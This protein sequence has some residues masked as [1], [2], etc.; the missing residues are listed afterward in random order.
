[1]NFVFVCSELLMFVDK[2]SK[3]NVV[4][5]KIEEGETWQ[6][7][8]MREIREEVGAIVNKLSVVGYVV[9]ENHG[10]SIFPPKTYFPVCYSFA[11]EIIDDWQ[12][13]KTGAHPFV[14]AYYLL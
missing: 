11:S 6:E 13:I 9:C 1:M 4:C 14:L 7:S 3:W 8:V 10:E 2:D 12:K 5:G